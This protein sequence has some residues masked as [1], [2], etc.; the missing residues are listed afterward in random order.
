MLSVPKL[1]TLDS[2]A[3]GAV[4]E[5]D[6]LLCLPTNH[7]LK[8]MTIILMLAVMMMAMRMMTDDDDEVDDQNLV[9]EVRIL[10]ELAPLPA[11]QRS[12]AKITNVSPG[13]LFKEAE[14][15]RLQLIGQVVEVDGVGGCHSGL[16]CKHPFLLAFQIKLIPQKLI[17]SLRHENHFHFLFGCTLFS[18]EFGFLVIYF[19]LQ[20]VKDP[21]KAQ[22][23]LFAFQFNTD[24]KDNLVLEKKQF[25]QR[26]F[27]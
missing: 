16:C 10:C 6:D 24:N 4:E 1:D 23:L 9:P 19:S 12:I 27:W 3:P 20:I 17:H 25:I 18:N 15:E 13:W 11:D 26:S 2:G 7:N 8:M 22:E 21:T 14:Y 5:P